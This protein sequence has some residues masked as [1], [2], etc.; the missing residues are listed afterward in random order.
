MKSTIFSGK[1]QKSEIDIFGDMV[2]SELKGLSCSILKVNFKHEVNNLI[3]KYQML[4]LQQNTQ[5]NLQSDHQPSPF[6]LKLPLLKV[7]VCN[8]HGK[9]EWKKWL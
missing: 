6:G 4:N 7:M 9:H 5:S 3:F 8:I 2:A 1:V